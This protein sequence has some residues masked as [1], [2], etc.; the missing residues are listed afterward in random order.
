[1]V[2]SNNNRRRDGK[3]DEEFHARDAANRHWMARA[4]AQAK[5]RGDIAVVLAMQADTVFWPVRD[6]ESGF[7]AW[8]EDFE[9]EAKAWGK[10]VLLI[11]GDTH[12][13]RLDQPYGAGTANRL[14]NVTR[15]VVPGA[16][17]VAAVLVQVDTDRQSAPFSFS[18]LYPD[19]EHSL[20]YRR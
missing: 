18:L 14:P 17:H 19:E 2:G 6:A 7:K 1:M 4:F 10:P 12:R 3:T 16:G 20:A 5:A 13:F 8:R 15:L 11:Q 9:R